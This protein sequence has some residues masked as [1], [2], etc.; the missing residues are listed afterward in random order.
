[1]P[2]ATDF[3]PVQSLLPMEF[4]FPKPGT[5][6]PFAIIRWVNVQLEGE[7]TSRWRTVT[8]H[9][10]PKRRRLLADGYY[11]EIEDAAFACH[12]HAIHA[13]I[14]PELDETRR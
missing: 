1:L 13:G 6:E 14:R 8:W 11:R 2:T 5:K 3:R 7:P 10:D 4:I 9:E 12:R